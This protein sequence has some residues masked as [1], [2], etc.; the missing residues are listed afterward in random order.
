MGRYPAHQQGALPA[1]QAV[2]SGGTCA[3][4]ARYPVH[5]P[6]YGRVGREKCAIHGKHLTL[7]GRRCPAAERTLPPLSQVAVKAC[8]T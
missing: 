8:T 5:H 7:C 2:S 6:R 4:R 3:T 1:G